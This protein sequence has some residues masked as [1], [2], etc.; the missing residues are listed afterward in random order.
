[1]ITDQQLEAIKNKAKTE[2]SNTNNLLHQMDHIHDVVDN[3]RELTQI[4]NLQDKIDN[5]LLLACCYLHDLTYASNPF[6]LK[7]YIFEGKLVQK[8][9]RKILKQ[10]NANIPDTQSILHALKNHPHS[11]PFKKL[12]KDQDLY[13]SLLQDA[14]TIDVFDEDRL[15][16]LFHSLGI[17]NRIIKSFVKFGFENLEDYLN[18][19]SVADHFRA[20]YMETQTL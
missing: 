17:K 20:K 16:K 11:F 1:M 15:K 5:N 7:A 2:M 3:A 18:F 13:S 4:L 8:P 19:P 12:N 9:A 10:V 14:D 6:F